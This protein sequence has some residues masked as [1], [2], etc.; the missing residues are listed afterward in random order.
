[1]VDNQ[2]RKI[3]G[4]RELSEDEIGAMNNCKQV[5]VLVGGLCDKIEKEFPTLDRRWAD[6]ARTNLQT[7]FMQLIREHRRAGD[8]LM[9]FTGRCRGG[10]WDGK[11]MDAATAV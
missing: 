4:Y 1:M 7:G 5:A 11:D 10:P 8:I 9:P 3:T 2:H 6:I